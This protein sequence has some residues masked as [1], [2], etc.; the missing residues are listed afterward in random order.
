M[1]NLERRIERTMSSLKRR[2][3][4]SPHARVR[5]RAIQRNEALRP[6]LTPAHLS[7]RRPRHSE[8]INMRIVCARFLYSSTRFRSFQWLFR[9]RR[10]SSLTFGVPF[11]SRAS[12]HA[13]PSF[14]AKCREI[15]FIFFL[16]SHGSLHCGNHHTYYGGKFLVR[17]HS[18]QFRAYGKLS[19]GKT[20]DGFLSA[21]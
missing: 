16:R 14:Y 13:P 1:S 6:Q 17:A 3:E 8:R 11:A 7:Q 5:T 15:L 12:G 10:D 19:C 2:I 21:S 9:S 18:R 20:G 4:R